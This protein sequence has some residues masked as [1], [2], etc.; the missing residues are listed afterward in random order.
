MLSTLMWKVKS[1]A[2]DQS[3]P[4]PPPPP[5]ADQIGLQSEKQISQAVGVVVVTVFVEI[6]IEVLQSIWMHEEDSG[7]TT[8]GV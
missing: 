7:T 4:P 2:W 5:A 1:R 6:A 3:P 8:P